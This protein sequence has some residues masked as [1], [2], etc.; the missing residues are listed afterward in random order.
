MS[1]PKLSLFIMCT[2]G[3]ISNHLY[4]F[5]SAKRPISIHLFTIL[6]VEGFKFAIASMLF[7]VTI[8]PI[9]KQ[10]NTQI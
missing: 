8:D 7:N 9:I 6:Y 2:R 1:N 4:F 3:Q 5:F 10:K